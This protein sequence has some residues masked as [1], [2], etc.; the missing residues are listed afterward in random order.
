VSVTAS[1]A[2][3]RRQLLLARV[4]EA[5]L[6]AALEQEWVTGRMP[7]EARPA[8]R[9]GLRIEFPTGGDH[10][11]IR[12]DRVEVDRG[13]SW[14]APRTAVLSILAA[15]LLALGAGA[16]G[17]PRAVGAALGCLAVAGIALAVAEDP[18][19]AIPFL[20]TLAGIAAAAALLLGLLGAVAGR[21]V[22]RL[23]V[24][25]LLA[26]GLGFTGWLTATAW[27]LY[28]GGHFVFH[29]NIAEEIWKGQFLVYY[30][31]YPGSMLSRQ[32]QWGQIIVP[33]PCLEQTLMAP[34]A[35]LPKGAFHL[36]EKAV[37]AGWLALIAWIA[38]LL[39]RRLA[40]PPAS[41]FAAI[42]AA[43]LVPT[44]QLLGLGHLMTILGC[45]G[46]ALALGFLALR[47]DQLAGRG[48][49]WA[50]VGLL[51]FAFLTYF[52]TLLFT[53]LTGLL[54]V[55]LLWRRERP[56]ARRV[57]LGLVAAGVLAFALYYVHWAWPFLSQS[58]PRILGG[59][60]GSAAES[61]IQIVKRLALQPHKL[62]YS[63]GSSLV[64]LVGLVALGLLPPGRPRLVLACWG[65]V[66][67]IVSVLDLWY[68]FLLK[69]HYFAMA[70]VALGWGVFLARLWEVGRLGRVAAVLLTALLV[71]LGLD[72][73][74]AVATGRI[75]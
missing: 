48:P 66:L 35:A 62:D 51:A 72:T 25:A 1:V 20:P 3:G 56:V 9:S 50:F 12:V 36:A 74:F 43:G 40:G 21:S 34:L 60:A 22:A 15:L 67:A 27:P 39:A 55:A 33:H 26:L 38:A 63:F 57:L 31:P 4:G 13:R 37:L 71:T 49:F 68:N 44:Y 52:A 8:W 30:L 7:A 61:G 75:P 32:A 59:S 64:P 10:P 46:A 45:L 65:S 47:A 5:G 16:A 14:P 58:V 23:P 28:R 53:G 54:I 29:S 73:A 69:H 41:A 19:I 70:P 42:V 24:A 6:L 2:S 11:A 17:A 18:L